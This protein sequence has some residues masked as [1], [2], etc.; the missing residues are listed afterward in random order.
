MRCLERGWK[1][2]C[3]VREGRRG[4][5]R[6]LFLKTG[7]CA[8][9]GGVR[10]DLSEVYSHASVCVCWGGGCLSVRAYVGE[11]IWKEVMK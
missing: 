4:S 2:E 9:R 11:G 1:E 6:F 3:G 10:P 8:S 5:G 7:E